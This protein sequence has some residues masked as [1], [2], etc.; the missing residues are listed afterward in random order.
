MLDLSEKQT[1]LHKPRNG[2]PVFISLEIDE[3]KL[4]N[5]VDKNLYNKKV[6]SS[7]IVTTIN[8]IKEHLISLIE[9]L[10][11]D[12]IYNNTLNHVYDNLFQ[13]LK[14]L[15]LDDYSK[16]IY[17]NEFYYYLPLLDDDILFHFD[18]IQVYFLCTFFKK[19]F[20]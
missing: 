19:M 17:D 6:I 2:L 16:W 5:I 14:V 11:Y 13:S 12:R 15:D 18:L 10:R 4:R 8:D 9:K 7:D 1:M 20:N 3:Y